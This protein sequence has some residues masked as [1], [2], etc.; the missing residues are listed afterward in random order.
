[1]TDAPPLRIRRI[2]SLPR[3]LV[4]LAHES[5]TEGFGLLDR[6][7]RDWTSGENRFDRAGEAFFAARLGGRL[8]GVCGVNRDPYLDD[9]VVGR[10]RHL[11]VT[12]D[13]RRHGVGASL[14]A[15]ALDHAGAHFRR[16]RLRSGEAGEF[17]ERLG[18]VRS[19]E[20]DAT[21]EIRCT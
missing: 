14:V 2:H 12:P 19:S 18:F 3:G 15:E 9:P 21:H 16:V 20:P 1:M 4:R 11:Y 7:V 13:R 8:V 5:R 10:L 17:Y 6:L